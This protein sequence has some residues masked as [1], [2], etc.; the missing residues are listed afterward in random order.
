MQNVLW[1]SMRGG[2]S[3]VRSAQSEKKTAQPFAGACSTT[4]LSLCRGFA[5]DQQDKCC[6]GVLGQG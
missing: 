1:G 3:V 6:L 4:I 5:H 2:L